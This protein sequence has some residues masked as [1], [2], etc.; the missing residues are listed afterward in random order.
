MTQHTIAPESIAVP[1]GAALKPKPKKPLRFKIGVGLLIFYPFMYLI[2]PISA[3]L[4]I[5]VGFKVGLVAGVLGAAEGVLLLAI[6]CVGKEAF[7]AIKAKL[8]LGKKKRAEQE[9]ALLAEEE[10]AAASP[11][12]DTPESPKGR[13]A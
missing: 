11:T 1:D 2:I 7:Q 6:A 10:P 9:A 4:P 8:G 12:T 3:F 13:D 5:E